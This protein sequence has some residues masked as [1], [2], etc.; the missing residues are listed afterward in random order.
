MQTIDRAPG[1]NCFEVILCFENNSWLF[2]T[3]ADTFQVEAALEQAEDEFFIHSS[4]HD[5]GAVKASS[6]F[7]LTEYGNHYFSKRNGKWQTASS[8]S[9]QGS[10]VASRIIPF[11]VG[12]TSREGARTTIPH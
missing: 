8:S 9:G 2:S 12:D 1:P 5:I 10:A 11:P 7:V 6:A 4:L 3:Y